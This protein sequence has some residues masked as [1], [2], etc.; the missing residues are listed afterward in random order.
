MR[1]VVY[2][3][4]FSSVACPHLTGQVAA[5]HPEEAFL[6][7]DQ[8]FIPAWFYTRESETHKAKQAVFSLEF[9]W[10]KVRQ[11]Y[12]TML[13]PTAELRQTLET[14]GN[15]LADAY[16]AIDNNQPALA[17]NLLEHAQYELRQLRSLH[18]IAYCLD[19]WFD[20]LEA[21]T[22][23][24]EILNDPQLCLL[25]WETVEAE[26]E[27]TNGLWK[28]VL[29]QSLD[30]RRFNWSAE[31]SARMR[32]LR[33]DINGKMIALD[34]AMSTADQDIAMQA[35]REAEASFLKALRLF[36]NFAIESYFAEQPNTQP[37]N[38]TRVL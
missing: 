38:K 7:F 28:K 3:L 14:T 21:I 31:Q 32:R 9:Q 15:W 36:G 26:V 22:Q 27:K 23:V 10:Q 5:P 12:A 24:A 2:I 18:R 6:R 1:S 19:P 13:P 34:R 4:L 33:Q 17:N 30:A 25:E 37:D 16:L 8:I 29:Q 20:M 11:T 35:A